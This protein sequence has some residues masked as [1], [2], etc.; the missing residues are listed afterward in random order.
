LVLVFIV[1]QNFVK[2][3]TNL[4]KYKY[5]NES[6]SDFISQKS[7]NIVSSNIKY[8]SQKYKKYFDIYS[9]YSLQKYISD[10]LLLNNK[11]Y[12]PSD[13]TQIDSEY[14]VNRA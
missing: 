2:A 12:S 14:V 7:L 8:S 6:I 10:D 9:D 11:K 1:Q 3:E 4:E 13:L 5:S